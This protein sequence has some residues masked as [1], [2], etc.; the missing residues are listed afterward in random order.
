MNTEDQNIDEHNKTMLKN[1]AKKKYLAAKE[2]YEKRII[3]GECKKSPW[4]EFIMSEIRFHAGIYNV[5][6]NLIIKAMTKFAEVMELCD[7]CSVNPEDADKHKHMMKLMFKE[8]DKYR[9]VLELCNAISYFGNKKF[10]MMES[11]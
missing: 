7:N 6:Y 4:M 10:V 9:R 5:D 3:E 11:N 1:N 2:D 8:M